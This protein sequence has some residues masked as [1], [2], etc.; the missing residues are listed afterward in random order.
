MREKIMRYTKKDVRKKKNL[1]SVLIITV[2]LVLCSVSPVTAWVTVTISPDRHS[3]CPQISS[4][5]GSPI[6]ADKTVT[7][8]VTVETNCP[9]ASVAIIPGNAHANWFSWLSKTMPWPNTAKTWPLDIKVPLTL[10]KDAGGVYTFSVTA[11]D[12]CGSSARTTATLVVQD[13]DYVSETYVA[14]TGNV[15][16]NKKVRSMA[17]VVSLDNSI[18]FD[19]TVDCVRQNV[20]LI[21][22]ARGANANFEKETEVLNY[23]KIG[24]NLIDEER[25]KSCAALGG[26]GVYIYEYQ[27]VS[28]MEYKRENINHHVTG[29]QRYK[30][31]MTVLKRFNGTFVIDV[32]Q[33]VPCSRHVRDREEFHGNLTVHKHVI[34]RRPP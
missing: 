8:A 30:T 27:N 11:V 4:Y 32:R 1:S 15:T 12:S 21:E 5:F 14:G 29:D 17:A 22:D 25:F 9:P 26:T 6:L 28:W 13:H 34:L 10:G 19:G 24:Q 31:E 20:Y 7:Y 3:T 23:R 33:S 2:F 16:L 18:S